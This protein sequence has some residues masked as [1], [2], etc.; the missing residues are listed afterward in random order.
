M[1]TFLMRLSCCIVPGNLSKT[2]SLLSLSAFALLCSQALAISFCFPFNI[3]ITTCCLLYRHLTYFQSISFQNWVNKWVI[4]LLSGIKTAFLDQSLHRQPF[5][6]L[7]FSPFSFL[8]FPSLSNLFYFILFQ[9][10]KWLS[11]VSFKPCK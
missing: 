3:G 4:L 10:A 11:F 7:F 5:C 9:L 6:S 1:T 2:S 8:N